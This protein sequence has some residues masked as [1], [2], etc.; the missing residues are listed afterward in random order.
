M[1]NLFKN[2]GNIKRSFDENGI[3]A[4]NN[5]NKVQQENRDTKKVVMKH[6]R[7][8]SIYISNEKNNGISDSTMVISSM[9]K[10]PSG[11]LAY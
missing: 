3:G 5:K 2:F 4:I 6:G 11:K 7:S 1:A 10:N 9:E 8:G